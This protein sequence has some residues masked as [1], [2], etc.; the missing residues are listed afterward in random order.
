[1]KRF[2]LILLLVTAVAVSSCGGDDKGDSATENKSGGSTTY[3]YEL[4]ENGCETGSH[5]FDSKTDYCEGLR[6]N[7]LNK[8]CAYSLRKYT[9]ESNNCSGTF[10][11]KP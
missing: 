9:Y 5:T 8:G 1:M 11:T 10:S 3:T 6:S 4:T 7:N 2:P